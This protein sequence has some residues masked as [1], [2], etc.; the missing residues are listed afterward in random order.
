MLLTTHVN[1]IFVLGR[2]ERLCCHDSLI[3]FVIKKKM[4]TNMYFDVN[5]INKQFLSIRKFPTC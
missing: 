1:F 4:H 2:G 5:F 3:D